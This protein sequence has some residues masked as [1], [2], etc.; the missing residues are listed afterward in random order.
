MAIAI[1]NPYGLDNTVTVGVISAVNRSLL[2]SNNYIIKGIIQ[3]DAAVNPGNSGGPL[4][5]SRGEVIGINSA[6]VSTTEGFQGIGFAIPINTARDIAFELIE[7]GKVVRPWLG[8]TGLSITPD[9]S[10]RYNLTVESGVLIIDVVEGGPA[11]KAGLQGTKSRDDREDFV[12]GDIITEMDG[13]KLETI[14]ELIDVILAH[15]VGEQVEVKYLRDGI[16]ETVEV[17]LGER[18]AQ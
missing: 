17:R 8:I 18:P 5:N 14:D 2:S 13:Q 12:M 1:G 7:E 10:K 11:E 16:E 9:I 4:L 6:I 15:R 3:T